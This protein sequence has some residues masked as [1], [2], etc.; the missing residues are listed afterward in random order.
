M[1][2]WIYALAGCSRS[3]LHASRHICKHANNPYKSSINLRVPNTK[4]FEKRAGAW[5]LAH[6]GAWRLT[7]IMPPLNSKCVRMTCTGKRSCLSHTSRAQASEGNQKRPKVSKAEHTNQCGLS[8]GDM[9]L[10][11]FTMIKVTP[12]KVGKGKQHDTTPFSDLDVSQKR[13]T[14]SPNRK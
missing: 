8:F 12:Q 2:P 13:C 7:A 5:R 9:W 10:W 6:L 1:T 14:Q 11:C 4:A 3:H